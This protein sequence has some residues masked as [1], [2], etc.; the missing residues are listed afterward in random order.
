MPR[1]KVPP[2]RRSKRSCSSA[3]SWRGANLSCCATSESARPRASRARCSSA[4]TLSAL[5]VI[6]PLLQGA[7]LGRPGEAPAQLLGIAALGEPVACAALDPH[8]EPQRFRALALHLVVA[9]HEAARLVDAPLPIADG[10]ELE[11][12]GR[13]VGLQAQRPLEELVGVLDVV[14]AQAAQPGR[15]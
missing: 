13:L 2:G 14:L 9:V 1:A 8:A 12:R 3:S 15:R 10:G 5:S 6:G 7:C 4:P 11:R